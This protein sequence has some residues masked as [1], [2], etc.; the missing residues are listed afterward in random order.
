MENS[1]VNRLSFWAS[2]T[3]KLSSFIMLLLQL[4]GGLIFYNGIASLSSSCRIGFANGINLKNHVKDLIEWLKNVFTGKADVFPGLLIF[5]HSVVLIIAAVSF[6]ISLVRFFF[7]FFGSED[8][9]L[10]NHKNS[11]AISRRFIASSGWM[12]FFMLLASWVFPVKLLNSAKLLIIVVAAGVLISRL[13][14]CILSKAPFMTCVFQIVY[15]AI[16][17][18]II[19]LV[20][21]NTSYYVITSVDTLVHFMKGLTFKVMLDFIYVVAWYV[22]CGLMSLTALGMITSC[23]ST[24]ALPNKGTKRAG[25][26][27]LVLS[28]LG[29]ALLILINESFAKERLISYASFLLVGV[30]AF[31]FGM[32]EPKL[33][34][35]QADDEEPMDE[36]E[37]EEEPAPVEEPSEEEE[38]KP[39]KKKKDKK[40]SEPK[41]EPQP[42]PQP[43]PE[44][45]PVPKI[46]FVGK[47]TKKIKAKK[48]RH[49]Q[50]INVIVIPE[51]VVYIE[52]YAFF[53]C[54]ELTEIHCE[55]KS[56]PR[57]WHNQWNFGCPAKVVWDS[58][59]DGMSDV[60]D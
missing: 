45:K 29:V 49:R 2:L 6:I 36:E 55:R 56:K 48:Y 8:K 46:V 10:R 60:Q 39:K 30:A 14:R 4:Y 25:A 28:V 13:S 54:T 47:R 41:P 32:I 43:E 40:K 11:F 59:N 17:F 12:L 52:G 7:L 26:I 58:A 50:D 53:G 57:F 27:L 16:M 34:K 20:M 19:G 51:S 38:D 31:I 44:V 1:N 23:R 15:C 5:L 37:P 22:V 42:E 35:K 21:M 33:E 18:A 9:L 3:A 24:I